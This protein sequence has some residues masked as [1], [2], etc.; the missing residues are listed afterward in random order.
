MSAIPL[1]E[2]GMAR[3][4]VRLS[5]DVPSPRDPDQLVATHKTAACMRGA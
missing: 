4:R 2:P 3:E 1:H 5:G